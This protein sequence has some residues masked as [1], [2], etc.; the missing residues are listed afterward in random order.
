MGLERNLSAPLSLASCCSLLFLDAVLAG[1]DEDGDVARGVVRPDAGAQVAAA[2][3]G[4]H[5]VGDH[6]VRK[7][8]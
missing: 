3:A 8:P 7:R 1:Q 2:F 5:Q 6:G 4:H